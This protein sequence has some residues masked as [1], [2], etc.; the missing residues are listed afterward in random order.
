MTNRHYAGL[1]TSS[2]SGFGIDAVLD[3]YLGT[4]PDEGDS[5]VSLNKRHESIVKLVAVA[6]TAALRAAEPRRLGISSATDAFHPLT[7]TALQS[8]SDQQATTL[9][10]REQLARV[11]RKAL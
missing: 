4:K 3:R 9:K 5:D 8:A 7:T 1:A 6:F 10:L 11:L 2:T